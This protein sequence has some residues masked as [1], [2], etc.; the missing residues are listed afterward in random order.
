MRNLRKVQ[1]SLTTISVLIAKAVRDGRCTDKLVKR[2]KELEQEF[3]RL[4]KDLVLKNS[5]CFSYD[6]ITSN[7]TY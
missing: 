7:E 5:L 6:T 4:E 2:R 1:N 3:D